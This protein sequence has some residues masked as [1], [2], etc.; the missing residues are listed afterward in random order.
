M[1]VAAVAVIAA[2]LSDWTRVSILN[3]ADGTLCVARIA[4]KVGVTS[5]TVSYHLDVLERVGLVSVHRHGRR[6]VPQRALD[7]GRQLAIALG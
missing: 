6:H 2:A 3:L 4:E 7:A 1:D 5:A